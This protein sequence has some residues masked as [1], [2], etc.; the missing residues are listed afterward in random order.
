VDYGFYL[1]MSQFLLWK[2][3]GFFTERFITIEKYNDKNQNKV[4]TIS[5][6]YTGSSW[7]FLESI[8]IRTDDKVIKLSPTT[9]PYRE[10]E[11]G[12][13]EERLTIALPKNVLLCILQCKSLTLQYYCR[14]STSPIDIPMDGLQ[15]LKEFISL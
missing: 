15:R 4:F 5:V 3:T 7:E 6:Y 12:G 8:A 9:S 1:N 11:Q 13:V 10:I 14:Y 2:Q